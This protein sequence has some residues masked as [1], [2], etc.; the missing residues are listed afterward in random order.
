MSDPFRNSVETKV[1]GLLSRFNSIEERVSTLEDNFEDLEENS[2]D[3]NVTPGKSFK[4]TF[5]EFLEKRKK[6]L[7]FFGVI[8]TIIF[9]VL[10]NIETPADRFARIESL[11]PIQR[12]SCENIGMHLAGI[13]YDRV[14]Y[15]CMDQNRVIRFYND[16]SFNVWPTQ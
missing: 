2:I 12:E 1:E 10:Y 11:R 6:I 14:G 13:G 5:F 9:L 8:G 16:G 15:S 4:S 3:K 7:L